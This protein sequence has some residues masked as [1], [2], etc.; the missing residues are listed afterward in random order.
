MSNQ[1]QK[2]YIK[3]QMEYQQTLQ[4][5]KW[6]ELPTIEKIL[7]SKEYKLIQWAFEHKESVLIE[8]L[9]QNWTSHVEKIV[10]FALKLR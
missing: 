6:T 10:D 8:S 1:I 5:R 4:D 7:C 2:E 9:K 3:A